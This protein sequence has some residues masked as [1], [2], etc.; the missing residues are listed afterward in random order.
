[1]TGVISVKEERSPFYNLVLL[2]LSVYVLCALLIEAFWVAD[3]E[4]KLVLQYIDFAVCVIFLFDFF[5]CLM[6]AKSKLSYMKWGWLD[7]V[8]SIPAIDPLRW[9]RVSKVV[10]IIRYLRAIKSIKVLL[11]SL[12][13]SRFETLTLSVF[14][15][16]FMSFSLSS[17]FILE[18]ERGF[19]SQ[20][21][22]AES[23][24]WWSFLNIMNAKASISQ[25]VSSEGAMMTLVL[26]K[27]GLLL[28][29]YGNS[30]VVAWL[31]TY[32][33]DSPVNHSLAEGSE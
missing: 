29:A 13:V 18:F 12:H 8:S 10:R 26:N 1:M 32:R 28:F 7:L 30:M 6:S 2:F 23:A 25:A 3:A 5:V 16:V 11:T 17:A 27:V 4:I 33:R 21:N 31:I 14:L 15:V 24:I 20:I 9:G 22:T 19:D